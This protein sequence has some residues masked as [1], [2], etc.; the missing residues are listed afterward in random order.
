MNPRIPRSNIFTTKSRKTRYHKPCPPASTPNNDKG[1]KSKN[2][3]A[4][5]HCNFCGKDGH[6]ESKCFKNMEAL[7]V[8]MKKHNINIHFSSHGHAHLAYGFSLNVT[9]TSSFDE[10]LVDSR[11][12]YHMD[13]DKAIFSTLNKCNTNKIFVGDD[14]YFSV[15][16][17]GTVQVDNDHFN[18]V[19][20]VPSISSNL[21]SSVSDHSFK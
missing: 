6:V 4:R 20:C 10:W 15:V 5:K 13:K 19:L 12:S 2:K 21:I 16:G 9:S 11:S 18:D 8:A 17:S 1:E 3:K 7:E 14:R